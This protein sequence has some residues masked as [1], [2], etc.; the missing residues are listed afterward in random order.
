MKKLWLFCL[1]FLALPLFAQAQTRARADGAA[2]YIGYKYIGVTPDNLLENKVKSNGGGLIT[3]ADAPATFAIADVSKGALRMLWLDLQIGKI[4]GGDLEW[5]VKDV[6]AF[7][8]LKKNQY[9]LIAGVGSCKQN[10]KPVSPT[11]VVKVEEAPRSYKQKVL[12]A[13]NVN[14]Q[15]EKFE[16]IS[17]RGIECFQE[18]P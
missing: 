4:G 16:P 18:E 14:L 9:L 5:Q 13:W 10:K 11:L 2:Q 8:N 3:T 6:L 17:I 1:L 7:P 15:T 12:Q